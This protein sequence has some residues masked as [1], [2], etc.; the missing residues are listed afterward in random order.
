MILELKISSSG[1]LAPSN[2]NYNPHA[3][4]KEKNHYGNKKENQIMIT[5]VFDNGATE[6]KLETL[7]IIF[8]QQ[9]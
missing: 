3:Y 9:P 1:K 5:N 8:T 2:S 7:S 6:D 4:R